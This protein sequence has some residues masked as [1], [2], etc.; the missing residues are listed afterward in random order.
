MYY[1]CS[2]LNNNKRSKTMYIFVYFSNAV[3]GNGVLYPPAGNARGAVEVDSSV[4]L[5]MPRPETMRTVEVA[6]INPSP[7]VQL[8]PAHLKCGIWASFTFATLFVAGAKFYF[9]H[10]VLYCMYA[11]CL[12][13]NVNVLM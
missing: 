7:P 8:M 4:Y 13:V 10:Q 12:L 11:Y 6:P 1:N 2:E 9:D 5:E 3:V